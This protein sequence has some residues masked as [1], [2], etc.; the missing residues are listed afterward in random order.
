MVQRGCR[1]CASFGAIAGRLIEI[2][3]FARSLTRLS[4]GRFSWP[5]EGSTNCW[6]WNHYRHFESGCATIQIKV[7]LA[8]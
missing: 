3:I 1:A 6:A 7:D 2:E 5:L 4:L 8:V